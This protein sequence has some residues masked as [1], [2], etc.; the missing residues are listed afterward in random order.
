MHNASVCGITGFWSFNG[1]NAD[2]MREV[3]EGMAN[4]LLHRG[5]DG[6]GVYVDGDAGLAFGFR[7]LAIIDLSNAGAQPMTSA[8]GRYVIIFNGEVYNHQRLRERLEAEQA[9][10]HWRGHSDTEVMLACIEAW[11]LERAVEQFIGM[12]AFALW[13]AREKTLSL[14]RDRAGVKPLYF[15]LTDKSILFASELKALTAHP[16]FDRTI[17]PIA[18]KLYA[19]YRYVPA[20][21]SIYLAARKLLPGSI[22]TIAGPDKV[23]GKR[24]WN[25]AEVW[26]RSLAS[27]VEMR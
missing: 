6:A 16:A 11:G 25:A 21:K 20:P 13:D 18:A 3:A 19:Q 10:P 2:A 14:V 12:F 23:E 1:G 15:A 24:Y 5:P 4:R 7:R 9:A 17:D 26:K 8:S 27:R 22:L